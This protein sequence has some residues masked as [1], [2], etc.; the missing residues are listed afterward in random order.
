MIPEPQ[1]FAYCVVDSS[2]D[3]NTRASSGR[4]AFRTLT[5]AILRR[6]S[7]REAYGFYDPTSARV[8]RY[9][10]DGWADD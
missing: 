9:K 7:D 5:H 4:W 2:G 1:L 10:F 8:A 6:D 3:L